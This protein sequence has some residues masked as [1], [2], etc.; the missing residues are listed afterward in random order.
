M[1]MTLVET[2]LFA[3]HH[4]SRISNVSHWHWFSEDVHLILTVFLSVVMK[5]TNT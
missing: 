5:Q 1:N 4:K 2:D 3:Q